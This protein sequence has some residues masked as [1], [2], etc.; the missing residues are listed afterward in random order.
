MAFSL[1]NIFGKKNKNKIL[2]F[3]GFINP[4]GKGEQPT[5]RDLSPK[6][7]PYIGSEPKTIKHLN[8]SNLL[9]KLRKNPP[10]LA[11]E[12]GILELYA[13]SNYI[14]KDEVYD[15]YLKNKLKR[16]EFNNIWNDT[17]EYIEIQ[18]ALV[19]QPGQKKRK[20]RFYINLKIQKNTLYPYLFFYRKSRELNKLIITNYGNSFSNMKIVF[21]KPDCDVLYSC[22]RQHFFIEKC[23]KMAG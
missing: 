20:P 18:D 19:R 14:S 2:P 6:Y 13:T 1:P 9:E 21:D 16:K 5:S 10:N 11:V 3:N 17:F 8:E 12:Q 4:R 22:K 23:D 7:R 15:N